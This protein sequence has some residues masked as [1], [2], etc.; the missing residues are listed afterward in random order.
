MIYVFMADGTEELEA[1]ATIDMLR[2][3]ELDVMTLGVNS[4]MIVSSHGVGIVCDADA[5]NIEPDETLQAVVIPGGMPGTLNIEKSPYAQKFIDYANEHGKIV[6]AICAAPSVLGHKGLLKGR[7][8]TCFPGFETEL[9]GAEYVDCGV[10]QDGN[11]ITAKGAGV[12]IEFG[13]KI[14]EQFVSKE[15]TDKIYLSIQKM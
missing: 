5:K 14:A 3:A 2:R 13:L 12:A 15:E 7:K 8:A 9:E 10:V 6:A 1:I 11:I 4:Q